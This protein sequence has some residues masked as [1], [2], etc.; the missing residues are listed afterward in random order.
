MP[1]GPQHMLGTWKIMRSPNQKLYI[2][3]ILLHLNNQLIIF[4]SLFYILLIIWSKFRFCILIAWE[5]WYYQFS[6]IYFLTYINVQQSYLKN[7]YL[8]KFCIKNI[9]FSCRSFVQ[10]IDKFTNNKTIRY[11]YIPLHTTYSI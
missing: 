2:F 8:T 1:I 11:N 5:F 3:P 4:S 7:I 10:S 6:L 9:D